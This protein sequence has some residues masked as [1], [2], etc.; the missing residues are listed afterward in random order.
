[1]VEIGHKFVVNA[2]LRYCSGPISRILIGC[3]CKQ[4]HFH[5]SHELADLSQIYLDN[6]LS[7]LATT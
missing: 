2:L 3:L 5:R 7:F 6:Q 4:A 1:M